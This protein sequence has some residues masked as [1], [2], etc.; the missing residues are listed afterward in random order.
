MNNEI[1]NYNI[2]ASPSRCETGSMRCHTNGRKWEGD[3][4]ETPLTGCCSC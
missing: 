2:L 3:S 4:T 1:R